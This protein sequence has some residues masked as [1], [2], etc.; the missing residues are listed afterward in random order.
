MLNLAYQFCGNREEARDLAQ[1][2]FVR[3]YQSLEHYQVGRSYMTWMY[4]IARNLCID[5][6]RKRRKDRRVVDTPVEEYHDLPSE[7]HGP[8]HQVME[9]ERAEIIQRALDTLGAASREAI[10]MKDFQ[11][12]SLEE[13]ANLL[14][15]P[16]GTVKSRISRA[17]VELGKAILRFE[18]L[19]TAEV[20]HG[21]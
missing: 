5:H 19:T 11:N 7:D 6:Y 20:S 1:D 21:V 12:L 15:V 2:I 9:R 3:L 14:G 13:M 8:E 4:S 17:R 10:V 16:I 18:R